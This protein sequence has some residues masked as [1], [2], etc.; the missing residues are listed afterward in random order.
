M[1]INGT[2]YT[3]ASPSGSY[4]KYGHITDCNGA[5]DRNPCP[6]FG[7]ATIDTGETGLIFDPT[8]R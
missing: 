3:F 7:N 2:D 1:K 8:V 5:A 4:L 6:R